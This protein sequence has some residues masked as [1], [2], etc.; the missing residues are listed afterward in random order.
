MVMSRMTPPFYLGQQPTE[1]IWVHLFTSVDQWGFLTSLW[2]HHHSSQ[3]LRSRNHLWADRLRQLPRAQRRPR[4]SNK[5]QLYQFCELLD[6]TFVNGVEEEVKIYE[7][8]KDDFS[9]QLN[10][11]V[12]TLGC[13][14]GAQEIVHVE[15]QLN[16][17]A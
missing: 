12:S 11:R 9:V 5:K 15:E 17:V 4:G 16:T 13:F 2:Q 8:K 7:L 3:L 14:C 6:I 1:H 10:S